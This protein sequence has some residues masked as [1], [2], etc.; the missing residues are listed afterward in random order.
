ML[1]SPAPGGRIRPWPS[2][3][4]HQSTRQGPWGWPQTPQISPSGLQVRPTVSRVAIGRPAASHGAGCN[5]GQQ[6]HQPQTARC[7]RT[8]ACRPAASLRAPPFPLRCTPRQADL[9]RAARAARPRAPPA[10]GSCMP[11]ALVGMPRMGASFRLTASIVD[12]RI[13]ISDTHCRLPSRAR[14]VSSLPCTRQA[15]KAGTQ[16]VSNPAPR[17]ANRNPSALRP[18]AWCLPPALQ[19][20][21]HP[22]GQHSRPSGAPAGSL[23]SLPG[24]GRR[25]PGAR[26]SRP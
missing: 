14:P 8:A 1:T 5:A 9:L 17:Q 3:G 25:R 12:D 22:P 24:W 6:P 2:G 7:S 18:P 10:L 21:S 16:A 23:P 11:P 19:L 15:E 20:P 4:R 13:C 26:G